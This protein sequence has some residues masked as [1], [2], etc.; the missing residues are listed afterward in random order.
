MLKTIKTKLQL[1]MILIRTELP[2]DDD[3]IIVCLGDT[4]SLWNKAPE[5]VKTAKTLYG[6]KNASKTLRKTLPI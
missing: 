1:I 4:T 6:A 2:E 3:S 5:A